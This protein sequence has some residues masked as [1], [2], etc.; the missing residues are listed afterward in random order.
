MHSVIHLFDTYVL[1][2]YFGSIAILGARDSAV[3]DKILAIKE[4]LFQ[5]GLTI[6]FFFLVYIM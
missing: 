6:F 2:T 4:L 1:S 5:W 3:N